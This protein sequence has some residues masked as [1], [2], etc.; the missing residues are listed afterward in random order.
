MLVLTRKQG[1]KI[2]IGDDIVIT[3]LDVRGDSIRIGVDAPRGV[4]IQRDEVLRAV[5]EAN[6]AASLAGQGDDDAEARLKA[7]LALLPTAPPA[8]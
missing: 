3:V 2:L 7:T 8:E 5:T 4:R 6:I 1:E